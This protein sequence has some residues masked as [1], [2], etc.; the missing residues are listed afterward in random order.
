[1]AALPMLSMGL[2]LVGGAT[3]AAGTLAGGNSAAAYGKAQ[4]QAYNMEAAQSFAS[5]QRQMLDTQDKTRMAISTIRANAGAS[6]VDAGSGS[7]AT[8]TGEVAQR[9]EYHALMDMFNGENRANQ[10][11]YQG[12]LA[13][14]EGEMKKTASRYTAFGT[15]AGTAGTATQTYAAFKY[16]TVYGRP[17]MALV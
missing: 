17:S 15:L 2:S 4:Q 12:T 11:R 5:G 1:M 13:D 3:M 9:G 6:G 8:T 16:P 10:L 14:T 7:P